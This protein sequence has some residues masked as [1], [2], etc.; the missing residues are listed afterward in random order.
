M[1]KEFCVRMRKAAGDKQ[2]THGKNLCEKV[3]LIK[4]LRQT[5]NVRTMLC[6][7]KVDR[8]NFRYNKL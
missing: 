6:A 1:E 4:R 3:K 5:S 7:V 2:G 8:A